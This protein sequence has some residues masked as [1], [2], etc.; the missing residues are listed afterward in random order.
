MCIPGRARLVG[1]LN[2]LEKWGRGGTRTAHHNAPNLVQKALESEA[3][4]YPDHQGLLIRAFLP[5]CLQSNKEK[6][7]LQRAEPKLDPIRTCFPGAQQRVKT[8]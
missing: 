7:N 2:S 6:S 1:K 8:Q 3:R 4:N 5:E